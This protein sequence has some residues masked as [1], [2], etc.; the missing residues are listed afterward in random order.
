MGL[1]VVDFENGVLHIREYDRVDVQNAKLFEHV[2][3][4][5]ASNSLV[6]IVVLIDARD[7]AVLTHDA[8]RHFVRVSSMENVLAYVVATRGFIVT[9][10][11]RI[12][13]L[14]NRERNTVIFEDWDKAVA[15]VQSLVNQAN[16]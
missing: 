12:L 2:I 11:A 16:V 10:A 5:Y 3:R 9:Q 14:R 13:E 4:E 6:P 8:T 1:E 7:V 15:H